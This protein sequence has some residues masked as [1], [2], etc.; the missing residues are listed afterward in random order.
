MKFDQKICIKIL[1][2]ALV[3]VA[4][5]WE[6]TLAHKKGIIPG[7]EVLEI[8]SQNTVDMSLLDLMFL[9]HDEKINTLTMVYKNDSGEH[10]VTLHK[11]TLLPELTTTMQ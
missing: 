1:I 11:E 2:L 3:L 4:G 7:D 8:N 6:N 9:T 5:V 10:T